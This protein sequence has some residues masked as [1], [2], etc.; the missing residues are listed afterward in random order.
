MPPV[1]SPGWVWVAGVVV[2]LC[3]VGYISISAG[4]VTL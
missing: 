1:P 4:I 3:M 2:T